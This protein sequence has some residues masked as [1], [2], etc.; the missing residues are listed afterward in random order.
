MH[1]R[2]LRAQHKVDHAD[3]LAIVENRIPAQRL[4]RLVPSLL[5]RLDLGV[6]KI[7]HSRECLDVL[8]QPLRLARSRHDGTSVG[9]LMSPLQQNLPLI[10]PE[11]ASDVADNIVGG[12]TGISEE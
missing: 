7:S 5:N 12:S 10:R 3:S 9:N 2:Q 6:R 11:F 8:L 1:V 4:R